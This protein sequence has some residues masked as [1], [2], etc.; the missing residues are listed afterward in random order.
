MGLRRLVRLIV[1]CC[2]GMPTLLLAQAQSPL[3]ARYLGVAGWE[4]TDGKTV[5]LIDPYV[6]R[7]SGPPGD[8]SPAP[9]GWRGMLSPQDLAIFDPAAVDRHITRADFILLTHGHYV[10]LLDV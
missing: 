1:C 10:H 3:H 6:S 5:I 2:L 8:G 4:I 9:P 7:P